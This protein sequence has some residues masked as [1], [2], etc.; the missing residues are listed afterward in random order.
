[1]DLSDIMSQRVGVTITVKPDL[2]KNNLFPPQ[3]VKDYT[4]L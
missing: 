4:S 1:M 3:D 2:F